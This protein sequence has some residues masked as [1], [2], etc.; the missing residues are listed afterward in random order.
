[1]S[2]KQF[3]EIRETIDGPELFC[4]RCKEWWFTDFFSQRSDP[5]RQHSP[6]MAWCKC[7]VKEDAAERKARKEAA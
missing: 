6:W 3:R 4:T 1:M 7:C 2:R 5:K